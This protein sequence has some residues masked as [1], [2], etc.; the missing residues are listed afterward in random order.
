VNETF[1][2][3]ANVAVS[4]MLNSLLLAGDSGERVAVVSA[5]GERAVL[6]EGNLVRLVV[7]Q[8]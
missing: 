7:R 8:G 4:T 2:L 1:L 6:G 3:T 5:V